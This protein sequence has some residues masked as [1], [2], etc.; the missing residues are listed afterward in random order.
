LILQAIKNNSFIKKCFS[1]NFVENWVA[2]KANRLLPFLQKTDNI[3]DIGTGNGLLAHTLMKKGFKIQ[4][5]D[6]ENHSIVDSVKTMIYD[7]KAL[8]FS[9]KSYDVALL[10]LVLHHTEDPIEVLKETARVANKIIIIEDVYDNILQKYMTFAMDTLVNFGHSNMTYQNR[11]IQEWQLIFKDLD[12]ELIE[13]KEKKVLLFFKQ[14]TFVL[15]HQ[16][17]QFTLLQSD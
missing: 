2:E 17:E 12:L 10:L 4:A 9:S 1:S 11:S 13:T 16:K 5:I 8:P 6:V 7:G 15:H 14:V 3:L